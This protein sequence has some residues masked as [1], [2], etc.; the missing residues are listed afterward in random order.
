MIKIKKAT[1]KDIYYIFSPLYTYRATEE[2]I[3]NTIRE[4][5]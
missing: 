1:K 3:N 5:Q 2:D 4:E